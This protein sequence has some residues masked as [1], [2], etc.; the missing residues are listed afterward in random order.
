[1]NRNTKKGFLSVE[2][3]IFVPIFVIAVLTLG[4]LIKVAFISES[5]MHAMADEAQR[6]SMYSYSIQSSLSFGDRLTTR[7]Y[8]E[9]RDIDDTGVETFWYLFNHAGKEDLI[10][11]RVSSN[12]KI[13]LPIVFHDSVDI[14]DTLLLRAFTGREFAPENANYDDMEE[15]QESRIVWVFPTAGER[16]HENSCGYI[17]VAARQAVFTYAIKTRYDPCKLCDASRIGIGSVIYYFDNSGAVYHV[18]S[19]FIVDRYVSSLDIEDAERR[20]YTPCSKCMNTG[21]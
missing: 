2:A 11:I 16:Y 4:Y 17:E 3:S 7:L 13:K 20:G 14:S 9:N 6:L 18:G 12:I 8:N 10:G 5:I 21:G 1:M 15:E 19:C